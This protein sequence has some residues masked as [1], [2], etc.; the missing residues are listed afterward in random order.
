MGK[1][2]KNAGTATTKSREARN[3]HQWAQKSLTTY[4]CQ[5]RFL[6]QFPPPLQPPTYGTEAPVL[7]T[8][9]KSRFFLAKIPTHLMCLWSVVEVQPFFF[10]S[11]Q[12]W[13]ICILCYPT[14]CLSSLPGMG[15][16]SECSI[17][18]N[19]NIIIIILVNTETEIYWLEKLS[20]SYRHF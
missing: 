3:K 16:W 6:L 8:P 12:V 10:T 17:M 15:K 13:L 11:T 9:S 7:L 20:C 1:I 19:N 5:L 14:F 4:C 18:T 2:C